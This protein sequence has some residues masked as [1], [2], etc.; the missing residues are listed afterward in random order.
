MLGK[1]THVVDYFGSAVFSDT[2]EVFDSLTGVRFENIDRKKIL[3][4]YVTLSAWS[5]IVGDLLL[6]STWGEVDRAILERR[7]EGFD[8][9][10]I[11]PLGPFNELSGLA[12]PIFC[13]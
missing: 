13:P 11:R 7:I 12:A 6:K 10:I 9:G 5:E 8:I 4:R 3:E 1:T 2:P